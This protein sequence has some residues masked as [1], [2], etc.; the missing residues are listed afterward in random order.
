MAILQQNAIYEI[1]PIMRQG[2]QTALNALHYKFT[3]LGAITATEADAASSFGNTFGDLIRA[4]MTT[5]ANYAGCEIQRI[6]PTRGDPVFSN[7]QA[8]AGTV[9]GDPMSPFTA[10]RIKKR[11]GVASRRARGRFYAAFPGEADNAVPGT[12]TAGYL[13]R[14]DALANFLETSI[15]LNPADPGETFAPGI[16]SRVAG[17]FTPLTDCLIIDEWGT[18]RTRSY[19]RGGDR[20]A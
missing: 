1:R 2:G 13:T 7:D 20:S 15:D 3:S 12:P 10:G 4:L 18:M 14:L 8:G 16:W 6:S 9:A 5:T 11:T 17:Q 19:I